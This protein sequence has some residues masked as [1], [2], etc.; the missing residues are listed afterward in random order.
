MS[1]LT[2]SRSASSQFG[3]VVIGFHQPGIPLFLI[4]ER[5]VGNVREKLPWEMTHIWTDWRKDYK[6]SLLM[7]K[8]DNRSDSKLES[9]SKDQGNFLTSC[10]YLPSILP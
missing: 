5:E 4:L 1:Q 7:L 8:A 3:E 2:T 10:L 9:V 6:C